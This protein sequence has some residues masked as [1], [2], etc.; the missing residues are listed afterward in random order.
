[1]ASKPAAPSAI[2]TTSHGSI[3]TGLLPMICDPGASAAPARKVFSNAARAS[4]DSKT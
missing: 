1:M 2:A 3:R 4:P